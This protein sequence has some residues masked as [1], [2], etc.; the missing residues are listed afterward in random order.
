MK[1]SEDGRAELVAALA[2]KGAHVD[3]EGTVRNF[4][5][6]LRGI[7]PEKAPH[8]AWQLLEHIRIAQADILDF[9]INPKYKEL[10]WPDEYWPKDPAP[11]NEAAWDASIAGYRRDSKAMQDLVSDTARDLHTRIPHGD[12]QTL[13][14]EALLVIDHNSYHLGQ[15]VFVRQSLGIWPPKK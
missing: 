3:F 13:F 6:N 4:P 12:G 1:T 2:G 9:C 8:T 7:R 11:P 5:P 10:Q 15:L 14:R